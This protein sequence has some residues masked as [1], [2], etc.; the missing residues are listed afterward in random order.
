[1]SEWHRVLKNGGLLLLLLP[2]RDGT[3]DWRRPLTTLDH[4]IADHSNQ[5]AENDLTH[6]TE[7]LDLHDLRKDIAAGT[8]EQFKARCLQNYSNRAMHQHVFDTLTALKT[9][10]HAK[11][12]IVRVDNL[13][14]YHIIILASRY[15]GDPDNRRF[16]EKGSEHWAQSP[17]ASD[18]R[19][20]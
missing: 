19:Y 13:K 20:C 11:F 15:E 10:D 16:L 1:L 12:R 6:L 4:M 5:V 2:H 7:V 18:R 3:F 17:F 9:V 14:P 8:K